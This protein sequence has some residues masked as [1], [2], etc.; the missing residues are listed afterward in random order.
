MARTRGSYNFSQNFEVF[1]TAPL[2][3]R[4]KVQYY[5]DLVDPTAWEDS[6]GYVWLY[7]GAVVVVTEDPSSGLYWLT[8]AANYQNYDS[9]RRIVSSL[10]GEGADGI[11][12]GD[13]SAGVYAGND[14]SGN[15]QFRTFSGSSGTTVTQVGDQIIIGVDAS[16][17]GQANY[18]ENV[19]DGD[20]SLYVQNVGD[21]LQFRELKAGQNLSIDVSGNLIIIDS[22]SLVSDASINYLFNWNTSQDASIQ[23]IDSSIS[24]LY[25]LVGDTSVKGAINVGDGSAN[26]YSDIDASGNI[27]LRTLSSSGGATVEQVGDQIIIGIDASYSGESNYGVNVGTGDAS[28]YSGKVGDALQFREFLAGDNVSLDVSGNLVVIGATGGPG[29][30]GIDGG[31]WITNI[32]PTS[33]GNVG[34]KVYSS[35]GNVLNSCLTDTSALTVA[36]LAL[37]GHTNYMPVVTINDVSISLSEGANQP[38]WTGTYNIEYEFSDASITV[39]HEDGASWSTTVDADTPAEILSAEFTGGYPGSQTE[40]KA[41]DTFDVS[42]VTDVPIVSVQVDDYGAFSSGT[43]TVSGTNVGFTGTIANRGTSTIAW[44]MRVRVVKS[45]GS[46]SDWYLSQSQGSVDGKDVVNLNNLYPSVSFGTITYPASQSAIKSGET[47]SVINTVSNYD[48]LTYS[49]PNGE[50]T[51]TSPTTYQT[52]KTVTYNSGGYNISS[53]NLRIVANRAANDADTT[54][55]T[56]VRIAN[57]PATLSVS[58]ASKF[59]SGGNDGTSVQHHQVAITSSQRLSSYPTLTKDTGGTWQ[60][61]NFS[62]TST[63]TV[64]TNNLSVSDDMA[65]ATYNWGAIS[66]TNLA[67][68]VTSTNSGTTQYILGGFVVRTLTLPAFGWQVNMNVAISDYTKLS[69]SGSGQVLD[70]TVPQNTRSTLGDV[71]RPQASTWSASA[72]GTNPTTINILDESATGSQSQATTFTIQEGI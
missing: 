47:A 18:G 55:N 45:T 72:T 23:R 37:P 43:F 49:S 33:G 14:A 21:A 10:T 30:A 63:A 34:D 25:G 46:T 17:P 69:S 65:K 57:T 67:G 71:T 2:D 60:N 50:L 9:W 54:A 38:L 5:A 13:G 36:V 15:L 1:R 4:Q 48:S 8:D 42:I 51:V 52:P 6:N 31:V 44:G 56:V 68:I 41:G 27:Q 20:A 70:W 22:S 3:A 32:T 26:V 35:D 40:L 12:I 19:G 29:G 11:N 16:Y 28:V 64:F 59:R 58:H 7:K 53:N 66:G 61:T 39:V 24:D 62:W